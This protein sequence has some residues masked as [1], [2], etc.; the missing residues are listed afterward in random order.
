MRLGKMVPQTPFRL[1]AVDGQKAGC[2]VDG[3]KIEGEFLTTI[4]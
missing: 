1:V 4:G 3:A 2:V